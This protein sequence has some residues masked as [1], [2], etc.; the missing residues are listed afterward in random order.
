MNIKGSAWF[1]PMQKQVS[2]IGI[3]LV[4]NGVVEKAYIGYGKG[5]NEQEDLDVIARRGAPF[6]LKQ[7]KELIK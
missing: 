7:A 2:C 1:T 6:P 5:E 4:D 3:V